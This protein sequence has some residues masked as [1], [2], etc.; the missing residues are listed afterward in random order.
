MLRIVNAN[1]QIRLRKIERESGINKKN[2]LRILVQHKFYPYRI[3]Q[4][5]HGTDFENCVTFYQWM[6]HQIHF[7]DDFFFINIIHR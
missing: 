7:N 2:I 4:N 1:P 6:Q 5:L 3:N